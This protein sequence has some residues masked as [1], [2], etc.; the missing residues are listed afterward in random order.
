MFIINWNRRSLRHQGVGLYNRLALETKTTGSKA[1]F[2]IEMKHYL[3]Y[4]KSKYIRNYETIELLPQR[5]WAPK[6]DDITYYMNDDGALIR[7]TIK[8]SKYRGD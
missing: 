5:I 4:S 2:R 7:N 6:R 1:A 3:K 8:L